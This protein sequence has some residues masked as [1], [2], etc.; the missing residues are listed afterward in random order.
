MGWYNVNER[1]P[2]RE[3][4]RYK[5]MHPGENAVGVI[6]ESKYWN[7]AVPMDWDG[8]EFKDLGNVFPVTRWMP[9]PALPDDYTN[10]YGVWLVSTEQSDD[11]YRPKF[12]GVYD[13]YVDE[14]AFLI[15]GMATKSLLFRRWNDQWSGYAVWHEYA[16]YVGCARDQVDIC[17]YDAEKQR[18]DGCDLVAYYEKMLCGS[19][20]QIS[21]SGME[22]FVTLRRSAKADTTE[23][24]GEND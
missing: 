10:P 18:P 7:V 2:D 24:G 9:M 4:E 22:R 20:A 16:P 21:E 13:G 5:K 19:N 3:L 12:I 17:V 8:K 11:D 6:C 23:G 1:L 14:I 15:A